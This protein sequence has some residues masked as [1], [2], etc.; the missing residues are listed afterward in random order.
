MNEESSLRTFSGRTQIHL[1][2]R[3][4]FFILNQDKNILRF[5]DGP[6]CKRNSFILEDNLIFPLIFY[7]MENK[8][9]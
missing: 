1:R 2:A 5:F 3:N 7:S 4:L 6:K 9:A 8:N